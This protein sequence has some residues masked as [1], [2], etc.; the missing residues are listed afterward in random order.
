M[1]LW[2]ACIALLAVSTPKALACGFYPFNEDVRFH[3]LEPNAFGYRDFAPFCFTT[4]RFAEVPELAPK[5]DTLVDGNILQWG[6]YCRGKVLTADI[7]T[8]VYELPFYEFDDH[9]HSTNPMVCY[10]QAKH[11]TAALYY[12]RFAKQVEGYN[13][14]TAD[15][16]ERTENATLPMQQ[17]KI[18]E[19]I[20][21]AMKSRHSELQTRYAFLAI[22]MA[23]YN[24]DTATAKAIWRRFF[25]KRRLHWTID[26]W[27]MHFRALSEGDSALRNYYAAQVFYHA[28]DKRKQIFQYYT[29]IPVKEYL[30]YAKNNKECAAVWLYEGVHNPGRALPEIKAMCRYAPHDPALGFL[31]LRE[32]SKLEDWIYTPTYT[33]FSPTL[34]EDRWEENKVPRNFRN[35]PRDRAYAAELRHIVTTHA[36]CNRENSALWQLSSAYLAAIAH[37]YSTALHILANVHGRDR[38]MDLAEQVK[39]FQTIW[40]IA[41]A[42]GGKAIIPNWAHRL[43]MDLSK[44]GNNRFLFAVARELEMH[45]NTTDAAL[46]FSR[47]NNQDVAQELVGD[48]GTGEVYWK[49]RRHIRRLSMDFF[50]DYYLYID[51]QYTPDQL[52]AMLRAIPHTLQTDS[53]ECW[54]YATV[55]RDRD[56]LQDMLGTKYIRRN[57]LPAALSAF[58]KV[59]AQLYTNPN[60]GFKVCLAANPFYTNFYN[61]HT[62]TTADTVVYTKAG[63]TRKMIEY[64]SLAESPA[65]KNRSYYYYLAATAYLNMTQ[66]G[67]SWMMRRYYWS[68]NGDPTGFEDDA[69]YFGAQLAK[70]YYLRAK[71]TAKSPMAAALCL[72]MAGRCEKYALLSDD[73]HSGY[74][75]DDTDHRLFASNKYWKQLMREYPEY[76]EEMLSNC[77]SFERYYAGMK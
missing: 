17:K 5:A 43:I 12:L 15:P 32:M 45:G 75:N 42:P 33:Y 56:R 6:E 48:G 13:S 22:R 23:Y 76:A 39:M 67:N 68:A 35:V 44:T 64:L 61:E 71:A 30:H 46:V 37:E 73:E 58:Y 77:L 21:Q 57:D 18:E 1:K 59:D 50:S 60:Y 41:E 70:Q 65:T 20:A 34:R 16:W 7:A 74:Y 72:R 2:I 4:Q 14:F 53:F 27:A 38:N 11:D 31:L 26:Y 69:E 62:P 66:Y 29:K 55:M 19:A 8:A 3:L 47:V 9:A 28:P 36:V 10:L 40:T 51:M 63:I 54:K 49:S 52:A 25:E 24:S